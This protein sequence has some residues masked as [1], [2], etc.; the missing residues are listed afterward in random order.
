MKTYVVLDLD[1][2]PIAV[3]SREERN[4]LKGLTAEGYA[5]KHYSPTVEYPDGELIFGPKLIRPHLKRDGV[6][7]ALVDPSII[8]AELGRQIRPIFPV[9]EDNQTVRRVDFS[10]D[11]GSGQFFELIE[12][13]CFSYRTTEA[14]ACERFVRNSRSPRERLLAAVREVAESFP[15]K[16][17]SLK[18]PNAA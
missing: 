16:V 11:K 9:A 3:I 7:V 15:L 5:L 1:L 8:R 10:N 2:K 14:S 6:Y 12:R 17:L 18:V 4:R 13:R